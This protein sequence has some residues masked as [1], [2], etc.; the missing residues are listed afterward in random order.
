MT[1]LYCKYIIIFQIWS[2]KNIRKIKIL[3]LF[4][5]RILWAQRD[6]NPR[7]LGCKPSALNQLSYA[8]RL[9]DCKYRLVF[10]IAKA[11]FEKNQI[12]SATTKVLPP[13]KI[14]SLEFAC[15]NA[16]LYASFTELY[17]SETNPKS[18]KNVFNVLS[19][20]PRG[21]SGLHK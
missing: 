12:I 6:S 18:L 15:I 4:N 3:K 17:S 19:S 16:E 14:K 1:R 10:Y 13:T 5:F 7:P 21:I 11:F 2:T 9:L 8:P 20:I